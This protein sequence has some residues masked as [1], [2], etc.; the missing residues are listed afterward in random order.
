[1]IGKGNFQCFSSQLP[2]PDDSCLPISFHHPCGPPRT[3]RE[4][5]PR[6]TPAHLSPGTGTVSPHAAV[7][8]QRAA[9]PGSRSR[10]GRGPTTWRAPTGGG[11][12]PGRAAR[13]P[14]PRPPVRPV[15]TPAPP[16]ALR[17]RGGARAA[18]P[19]RGPGG[20]GEG[21][22]RAGGRCPPQPAPHTPGSGR[23]RGSGCLPRGTSIHSHPSS[24]LPCPA[25]PAA[26]PRGDGACR[27]PA[28]L[29]PPPSR[30]R[31]APPRRR[32]SR[33]PPGEAGPPRARATRRHLRDWQRRPPPSLRGAEREGGRGG[34]G[35][36][37][38]LPRLG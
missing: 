6:R 17:E 12:A 19:S 34:G 10:R 16:P 38:V 22:P 11:T 25:R 14:P 20:T 31:A 23:R 5:E 4:G 3:S 32:K 36:R 9:G 8:P 33:P 30:L 27:R 18:P 2:S 7:A 13:N 28:A 1:M 37:H 35:K 15:E 26:A 29:T 24:P 21:R